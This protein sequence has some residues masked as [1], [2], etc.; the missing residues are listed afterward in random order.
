V[1]PG[2]KLVEPQKKKLVGPL[3]QKKQSFITLI[4]FPTGHCEMTDVTLLMLTTSG[5]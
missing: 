3:G 2:L 5:K 1:V 4:D